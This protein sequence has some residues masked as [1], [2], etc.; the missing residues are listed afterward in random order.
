MNNH[1]L[2]QFCYC[3]KCGSNHFEIR[4]EKAKKCET[5]GFVYYFNPSVAC[6]VLISDRQ[7]RLLVAVRAKD[8]A[9]GTYD[10]P[11][12]FADL[13]ETAEGT[14]IREVLEETGIDVCGTST[15]EIIK[16][17]RYLFS[18]PNIYV[19]SGFTVHTTDLVFH[20]EMES[21]DPYVGMGRDDVGQLLAV[22]L[23][24]LDPS[25]FGLDSI[26]RVVG[27]VIAEPALL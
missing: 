23:S 25:R 2:M 21:L 27:R 6:A 22:P 14:A 12:G 16:P 17:L 5:C 9:K 7:R 4:N 8:P 24:E 26:R 3:P 15:S 1:P 20:L 11:G 13:Y 18:E 19:Y 10:L